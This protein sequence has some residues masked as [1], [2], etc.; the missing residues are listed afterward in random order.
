MR[1]PVNMRSDT[2]GQFLVTFPDIPEAVTAIDS[3]RDLDAM[4]V[5]ALESA[6]DVYFDTKRAVPL[7]SRVK[8]GQLS[9]NLP[10]TAAAKAMLHNELLASGVKKA[11][12]A[13]RMN[14]A[15]PNVERLFQARHAT[16]FDTLEAAFAALGRR[17][18]VTVR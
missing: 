12:L 2:N 4:A 14:I 16:R 9:V 3:E 8:R 1:Y 17:L 15:A 13:R 10:A 5:D 6:L 18:E 7:P 11:E